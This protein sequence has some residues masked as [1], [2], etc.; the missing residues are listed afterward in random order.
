MSGLD[1]MLNRSFE[2]EQQE[3]DVER[4]RLEKLRDPFKKPKAA[5]S[6]ARPKYGRA[7]NARH[8]SANPG[9]SA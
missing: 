4:E 6:S 7:R 3:A 9:D 8:N 2:E 1:D 5:P